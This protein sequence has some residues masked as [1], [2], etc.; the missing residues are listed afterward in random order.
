MKLME[1][2]IENEKALLQKSNKGGDTDE[3]D[4]TLN[5]REHKEIKEPK[6]KKSKERTDSNSNI[7]QILKVQIPQEASLRLI[8]L[9]ARLKERGY[10]GKTED[11]ISHLWE[12]ISVEWCESRLEALTPDEYYLDAIKSHPEL[13]QKI[14]EQ[15]KKAFLK[16]RDESPK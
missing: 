7:T 4:S 10:S 8:D 2:E 3:S 12:Q 1:A 15:A 9:Q 16:I 5:M 13:R 14:I 11:V 6:E